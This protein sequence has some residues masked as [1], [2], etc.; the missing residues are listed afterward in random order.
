MSTFE[1]FLINLQGSCSDAQDLT[2]ELG[3]LDFFVQWPAI[4]TDRFTFLVYCPDAAVLHR[5]CA[6][7]KAVCFVTGVLT[8]VERVELDSG[9][10]IGTNQLYLVSLPE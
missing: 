6:K 7:Y 8:P 5:L 9:E 3:E 10:E 2:E 1:K 4:L